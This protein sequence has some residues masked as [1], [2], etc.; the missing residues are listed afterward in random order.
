MISKVQQLNFNW[1]FQKSI[2]HD[3]GPGIAHYRPT[4]AIAIAIESVALT[5]KEPG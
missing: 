5:M 1:N 4:I 2:V 3:A